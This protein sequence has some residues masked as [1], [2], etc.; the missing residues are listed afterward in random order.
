M[1][2]KPVGAEGVS[3]RVVLTGRIA[4]EAEKDAIPAATICLAVTTPSSPLPS[5][6]SRTLWINI[7]KSG[8]N[9]LVTEG[10]LL[11]TGKLRH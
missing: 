6:A 3:T 8:G 4:P 10:R 5:S 7:R 9:G 11:A 2:V 1:A